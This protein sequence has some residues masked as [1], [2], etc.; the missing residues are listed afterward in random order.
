MKKDGEKEIDRLLSL[1][2]KSEKDEM[3]KLGRGTRDISTRVTPKLLLQYYQNEGQEYIGK[4][5]ILDF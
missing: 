1:F 4:H 2:S 5:K 3:K